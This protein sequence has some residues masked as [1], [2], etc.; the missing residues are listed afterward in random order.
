MRLN[1]T[2]LKKNRL[3]FKSVPPVCENFAAAVRCCTHEHVVCTTTTDQN[4]NH[5]NDAISTIA[6]FSFTYNVNQPPTPKFYSMKKLRFVLMTV[7]AIALTFLS[8]FAF[9]QATVAT[10]S[11]DYQPGST[12]LITGSGF[13]PG[14]TVQLQVIHVGETG[15]NAFSGAH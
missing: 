5:K 14:E 6:S 12:V 3:V 13:E 4:L 2:L 1:F 9:G 15:D 10:D 11:A 7:S 8:S